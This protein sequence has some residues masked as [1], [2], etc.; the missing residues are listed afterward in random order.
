VPSFSDTYAAWEAAE[1]DAQTVPSAE[2]RIA[3]HQAH[4]ALTHHP[5]AHK[6][7]GQAQYAENRR[8]HGGKS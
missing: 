2:T 5:A 6:A 1:R 8:R 3:A 7:R 4:F